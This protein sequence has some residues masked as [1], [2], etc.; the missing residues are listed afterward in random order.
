MVEVFVVP[1]KPS[2]YFRGIFDSLVT[3]YSFQSIRLIEMNRVDKMFAAIAD[4]PNMNHFL[5]LFNGMDHCSSTHVLLHDADLFLSPGN[6]LRKHF[7][8]CASSHYNVLGVNVKKFTDD[9]RPLAATW[10]MMASMEWLKS[11]KPYELKA[12]VTFING[13]RYEFD[14]MLLPQYMTSPAKIALRS[15]DAEFVHINYLISRYRRYLKTQKPFEDSQFKLLFIKLLID[16]HDTAD[17]K[18]DVPSMENCIAGLTGHDSKVSYTQE[19]TASYYPYARGKIQ[20]LCQLGLL[21]PNQKKTIVR[22][23]EPFDQWFQWPQ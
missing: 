14:T 15:A 2:P 18:H 13:K 4:N 20:K 16:S 19:E 9:G 6:F 22:S 1:D 12:Q 11:F 3:D 23:I 8:A 17:W 21:T 5:Q 7:E 10:E